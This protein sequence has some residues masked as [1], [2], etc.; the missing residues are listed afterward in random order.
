MLLAE[1]TKGKL[2]TKNK[3]IKDAFKK[4]DLTVLDSIKMTSRM[5]R[6]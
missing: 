3:A 1:Y 6:G 2:F 4:M 5:E